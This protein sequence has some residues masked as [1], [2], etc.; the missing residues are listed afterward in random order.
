MIC[1]WKQW[2][3]AFT[4]KENH[5]IC[6]MEQPTY[7]LHQKWW[8]CFLYRT[9]FSFNLIIILD[10]FFFRFTHVLIV[11]GEEYYKNKVKEIPC[12]PWGKMTY[13][14]LLMFIYNK[15]QKT[16]ITVEFSAFTKIWKTKYKRSNYVYKK[17]GTCIK[18]RIFHHHLLH[19]SLTNFCITWD[20]LLYHTI[21]LSYQWTKINTRK[22]PDTVFIKSTHFKWTINPV[23]NSSY[24]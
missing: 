1:T 23:L 2:T 14:S 12:R 11:P 17:K 9:V 3:S 19:K 6:Y 15:I 10:E 24:F 18:F 7:T 21:L 13:C 22:I 16:K 20:H 5:F 8:P 4:L